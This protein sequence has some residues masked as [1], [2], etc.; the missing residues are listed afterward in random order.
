MSTIESN[1]ITMNSKGQPNIINSAVPITNPSNL[2][3][4]PPPP[5]LPLTSTASLPSSPTPFNDDKPIEKFYKK[6]KQILIEFDQIVKGICY[7]YFIIYDFYKD[8][9]WE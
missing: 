9:R 3:S 6:E 1:N 2:P 7:I 4:K 5:P 8:Y